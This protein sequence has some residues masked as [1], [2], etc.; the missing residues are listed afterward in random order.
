MDSS[1]QGRTRRLTTVVT[2]AA[3]LLASAGCATTTESAPDERLDSVTYLTGFGTFGRDAYAYVAAERGYF[4]DEG[5]EVDIQPGAGTIPNVTQT[6]AGQADFALSEFSGALIARTQG[7]VPPEFTVVAAIQQQ[8]L[9]AIIAL[10]D[11]G[12]T[13]PADLA[14]RTIGDAPGSVGPMLFPSYARLAGVDP[15]TVTVDNSFEPAQLPSLLATGTVDAIGQFLVGQPTIEA[16]ADQPTVVLPFSDHLPDLYGIALVVSEE[17]ANTDPD[18][19]QRFTR[20][21]LRGLETTIA[22]PDAAGQI[23]QEWV[24]EMDGTVAAAEIRLMAPYVT[25]TDGPFGTMDEQRVAEHIAALTDAGAIPP[26]MTP[27]EVVTFPLVPGH[28]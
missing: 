9:F 7:D 14:G 21:L 17:V 24:P 2:T 11:S 1:R 5:L 25:T 8:T 12:I 19:V 23:L 15:D 4:A 18:L 27:S 28:E 13:T 10:A 6:V 3:T 16:A 20:A 22:D 26:G